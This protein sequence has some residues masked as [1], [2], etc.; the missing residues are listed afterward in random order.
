MLKLRFYKS[1]WC[2]PWVTQ[3]QGGS[4]LHEVFDYFSLF[5]T[6]LR[7]I[8]GLLISHAYNVRTAPGRRRTLLFI[9]LFG[10]KFQSMKQPPGFW[11][12][13][14][15]VQ[16]FPW[17][18]YYNTSHIIHLNHVITENQGRLQLQKCCDIL[19][20]VAEQSALPLQTAQIFTDSDYS[21]SISSS[22]KYSWLLW[23]SVC[24]GSEIG[25][26][27]NTIISS[28]ACLLFTTVVH[29]INIW[30]QCTM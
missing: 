13:S 2:T 10:Y 27:W 1:I 8:D 20:K 7:A 25:P 28:G 18:G 17:S 6:A 24:N 16:N 15:V 23:S 21:S 3:Y 12:V 22:T 29:Y 5:W 19:G 9:L 30:S 11:T 26:T 4:N 14:S